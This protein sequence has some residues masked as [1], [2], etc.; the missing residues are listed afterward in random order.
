[1][2]VLIHGSFSKTRQTWWHSGEPF[3]KYLAKVFKRT[4]Y[5]FSWSGGILPAD[6]QSG[7]SLLFTW[8]SSHVPKHKRKIFIVA[9]SNGGNV[10]MLATHK[11]EKI[12]RLILLGTPLRTDCVPNIRKIGRLYNV[13]SLDD[14]V[15]KSWL[16]TFLHQRGEGRTLGDSQKLVNILAEYTH[17]P[18]NWPSHGGLHTE[19]VWKDCDIEQRVKVK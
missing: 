13:Y 12:D 5:P 10:A 18:G 1:M 7:A 16:A 11:T 14:W 3:P 4:V 8:I 17:S 9:H 6:F 15:Q 2:L 19:K